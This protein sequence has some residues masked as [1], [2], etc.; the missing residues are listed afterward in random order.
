MGVASKLTLNAT[1][2]PDFGQVEVDPE[3]VNLTDV[4]T[5]L[6]DIDQTI[7]RDNLQFKIWILFDQWC[8]DGSEHEG[9]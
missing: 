1:I 6:D 2:N 7:C 8:N 5:F 4:E 3:V 9:R